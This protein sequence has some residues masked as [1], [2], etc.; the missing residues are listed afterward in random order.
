MAD[1]LTP[2]YETIQ[3]IQ[4]KEAQRREQNRAAMA[5]WRPDC[6]RMID[7]LKEA[8]MFGRVVMFNVEHREAA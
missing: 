1:D 3:A 7:E 5:A 2:I 8:G 6:L 4:R